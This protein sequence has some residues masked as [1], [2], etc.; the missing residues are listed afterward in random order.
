MIKN[1]EELFDQERE[2]Y[3]EKAEYLHSIGH[4]LDKTVEELAVLIFNS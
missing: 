2:A 3:I 4:H 1:I